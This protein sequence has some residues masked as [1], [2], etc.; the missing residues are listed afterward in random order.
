MHAKH[1]AVGLAVLGLSACAGSPPAP[2]QPVSFSASHATPYHLGVDDTVDVSVWKNPDLS[3]SEP[4]RPDGKI[5]V[6][7]IGDVTASGRTPT[8]VA[9]RIRQ[10]LSYYIR[11]PQVAVIVTGMK[12]HEYLDRVRVTG[13]V[14]DPRSLTY[15]P[16]MTVLDAVLAAG[17]VNAFAAPNATKL[18]RDG[19]KQDK[20]ISVHLGNILSDGSMKTNF[21]L[22]PGDIISVPQ[23]LF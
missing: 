6:P 21:P 23:R 11:D 20:S 17:G 14:R 15:H 22:R 10:R 8:Q 2:P 4:V 1:L 19:P 3:V 13:A 18:Y 12:S 9:A 16:G 7:L 5:S